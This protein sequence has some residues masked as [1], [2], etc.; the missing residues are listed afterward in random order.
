MPGSFFAQYPRHRQLISLNKRFVRKGRSSEFAFRHDWNS[1]LDVRDSVNKTEPVTMRSTQLFPHADVMV[2]YLA[3]FAAEQKENIEYGVAVGSISKSADGNFILALEA[4]DRNA[5]QHTKDAAGKSERIAFCKEVVAATG[6]WTPKGAYGTVDGAE[7]VDGYEDLPQTGEA[8]EGKSV[9]VLGLGNAALETTQAL[10]PFTSEIHLFARGRNLPEGGEGVRFAH[11]T[12]YV[13][14]VRSGLTTVLDTYLLKS[15]DTFDFDAL[16][17]GKRLLVIPCLGNRIC[18]WGVEKDDCAD[19]ACKEQFANSG[20]NLTY[21]LP[22][23]SFS[24]DGLVHKRV[25]SLLQ[26]YAP[27]A[28]ED[29]DYKMEEFSKKDS[30]KSHLEEKGGYLETERMKKLGIHP[31]VFVDEGIELEVTS[32][33]LRSSRELTDELA[34]IRR[35]NSPDNLRY[36]VDHVIRCFGWKMDTSMFNDSISLGTMLEGRYPQL[37]FDYQAVGVP[38]LYF[39][40]T[41][42]HGNDF[43]RG[44]GGSIHGFRYTTRALFRLLEEK[45]HGIKWPSTVFQV[46]K[47]RGQLVDQLTGLLQQ[48]INEVSGAY[49]MIQTLG[50][51]IVFNV[52]N[53]SG[54]NTVH[55]LEEVP[56]RHFHE[57][58]FALPR[59]TW[60]FRYGRNFNGPKVLAPDRAGAT[61]PEEAHKSNFLHPMLAFM[62]AGK[63]EPSMRHF[64]TE[65]LFTQWKGFT[66]YAP[67]ALFVSRA[68]AEATGESSF[69][70]EGT[71]A[72]E[73]AKGTTCNVTA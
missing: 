4:V 5:T 56:L 24:N 65:D 68:I 9:I 50:D 63:Q 60:L 46:T 19:E 72:V 55:Y 26:K 25:K 38:G 16:N 49:H 28:R 27:G 73:L 47:D 35:E 11:Q 62:P 64:L 52:D 66:A 57:R 12:H 53:T 39:A 22:H 31:R 2:D 67:L 10:Q 30:L 7:Y 23:S 17:L 37:Q 44:A 18:C 15:L 54:Q 29:V 20:Q 3:D 59:L 43:Q 14:D 6:L 33:L 48:R 1:L 69:M 21:W 70:Q 51:M 71:F 40:G 42:A 13:E 45:N 34:L 8:Y 41:L 61:T 58:Y 32:A 36:P